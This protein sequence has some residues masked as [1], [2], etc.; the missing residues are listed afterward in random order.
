MTRD[1]I[2]L[3][4]ATR[5]DAC[6]LIDLPSFRDDRGTLAFMEGNR[7]IPFEIARV[8]YLYGVPGGSV[9]AGHA[10]KTCSQVVIAIGGSFTVD[11]SDGE[12]TREFKLSDPAKAV[13]LPP[14]IWREIRDFSP[15]STCLVLA[16]EPYDPNGYYELFEEYVAA[17]RGKK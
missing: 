11:V 10:L 14:K 17:V 2:S 4:N 16:S 6:A 1:Q 9:R 13:L 3:Q 12:S 8:F 5:V 7:H 15:G